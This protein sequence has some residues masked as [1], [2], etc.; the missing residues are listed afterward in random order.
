[1]ICC[2]PRRVMLC[3]P[4]SR[5]CSVEG[6]RPSFFENWAKVISPR[7]ARRNRPSWVSSEAGTA[8][9]LPAMSFQM[10]NNSGIVTQTVPAVRRRARRGRGADASAAVPSAR[11]RF[12]SRD[13][14]RH[15]CSRCGIIAGFA[16]YKRGGLPTLPRMGKIRR[17]GY[18]I[19]WFI[20]DHAPRHVHVETSAGRL[21]GRFNLETLTGMEGWQPGRKLLRIILELQKE[22]RL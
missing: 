19:K 18:V 5:R 6:G 8:R 1:M 7:R 15:F 21:I 12:H 20:G 17:G 4:C 22:G 9:R 10:R 2:R 11:H 14:L 3:A 13:G 16:L